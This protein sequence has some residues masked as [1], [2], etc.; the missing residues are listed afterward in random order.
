MAGSANIGNAYITIADV[1]PGTILGAH[2][3]TVTSTRG[4]PLI[5]V[6]SP[7]GDVT[8]QS[9][10]GLETAAAGITFTLN[11]G[12][13]AS[14]AGDAYAIGVLPSPVDLTGIAF[15][16][17]AR[18]SQT[19]ANV[20]L[21][22][23]STPAP[24]VVPTIAVGKKGGQMSLRVLHDK[25][26]RSRFP[27]GRYFYDILASADSLRVPAFYGIIEHFDGATYLP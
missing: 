20:A 6:T 8:S 24:G 22:A 18:S 25:M 2:V 14:V 10:I 17:Q 23:S 21:S 19:A 27:P 3:V 7:S 26:S 1:A 9:A 12:S 15:D 16:L 11:P 13:T 5:T 4:V